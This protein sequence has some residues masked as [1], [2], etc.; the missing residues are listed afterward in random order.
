MSDTDL[1]DGAAAAAAA[2]G[3]AGGFGERYST[4]SSWKINQCAASRYGSPFGVC[5]H[6]GELCCPINENTQSHSFYAAPCNLTGL[7]LEALGWHFRVSALLSPAPK[8]TDWR[9]IFK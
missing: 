8:M 7:P 5:I 9:G 3:A 4:D 1:Q 6:S 2:G